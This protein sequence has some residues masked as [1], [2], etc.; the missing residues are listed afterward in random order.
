MRALLRYR[1]VMKFTQKKKKNPNASDTGENSNYFL[2][3]YSTVCRL[4]WSYSV[5][6]EGYSHATWLKWENSDMFSS[7][8]ANIDLLNSSWEMSIICMWHYGMK[9]EGKYQQQVAKQNSKDWNWLI[10]LR[11]LRMLEQTYI[12]VVDM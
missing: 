2:P 12:L 7:F 5:I 4:R 9:A 6:N 3:L 11:L 10:V 8:R 1:N